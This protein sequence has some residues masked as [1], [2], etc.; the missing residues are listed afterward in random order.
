MIKVKEVT[1]SGEVI[2]TH[3]IGS[4][5]EILPSEEV[6]KRVRE[7]IQSNTI[8]TGTISLI[9]GPEL[10]LTSEQGEDHATP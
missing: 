9:W 1:D 7:I 10:D 4:P 3:L 2:R 6:L 8:D 5:G